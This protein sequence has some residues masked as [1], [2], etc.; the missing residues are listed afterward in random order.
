MSE[1]STFE[2]PYGSAKVILPTGR[3]Q[4]LVSAHILWGLCPAPHQHSGKTQEEAAEYTQGGW[5]W[6]RSSWSWLKLLCPEC[7]LG[8]QNHG[9]DRALWTGTVGLVL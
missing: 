6:A 1:G 3:G 2:E 9:C 5:P 8:Q 7:V 4:R